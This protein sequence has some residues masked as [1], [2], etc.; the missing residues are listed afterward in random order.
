MT[1]RK[2]ESG[3]GWAGGERLRAKVGR[4]KWKWKWKWEMGR[5]YSDKPASIKSRN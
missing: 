1:G 4:G 3:L 2:E 5:P